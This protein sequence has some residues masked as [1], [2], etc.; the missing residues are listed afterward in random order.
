MLSKYVTKK[1]RVERVT[2]K[3]KLHWLLKAPGSVLFNYCHFTFTCRL[4]SGVVTISNWRGYV[5]C[6]LNWSY[7]NTWFFLCGSGSKTFSSFQCLICKSVAKFSTEYLPYVFCVFDGKL[8]TEL[9]TCEDK[10]VVTVSS[11]Q[12]KKKTD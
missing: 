1:V 6:Y 2:L 7:K 4:P 8:G 3:R 10:K 9:S 5:W 12:K 11:M